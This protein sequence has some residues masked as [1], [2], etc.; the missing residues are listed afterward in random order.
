MFIIRCAWGQ[1]GESPGAR[2]RDLHFLF[3]GSWKTRKVMHEKQCEQETRAAGLGSK[4]VVLLAVCR[5]L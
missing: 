5:W 1:V 3:V 2:R 4:R